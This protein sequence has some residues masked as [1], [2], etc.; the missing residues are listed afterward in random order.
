MADRLFPRRMAGDHPRRTLCQNSKNPRKQL[1]LVA[2]GRRRHAPPRTLG[3]RA[4]CPRCH[5]A[6]RAGPVG[7]GTRCVARRV[8]RTTGVPQATRPLGRFPDRTRPAR[9]R[10]RRG[11]RAGAHPHMGR[12]A[13]GGRAQ[14]ARGASTGLVHPPGRQRLAEPLGQRGSRQVQA[15]LQQGPASSQSG[16]ALA[17]ATALH[18]C[19]VP[20]RPMCGVR[21]EGRSPPRRFG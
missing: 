10:P 6:I 8:L 7:P 1:G 14:P 12:V 18:T 11:G 9:R 2:P 5:G 20:A 19:A 16:G 15:V 4:I 21:R 13:C 3:L 17:L